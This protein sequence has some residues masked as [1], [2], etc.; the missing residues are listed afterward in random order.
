MI[1]LAI[2]STHEVHIWPI[3]TIVKIHIKCYEDGSWELNT[4]FTNGEREIFCL[5][6]DEIELF[7]KMNEANL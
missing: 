6:K 1:T 5:N 2:E 4:R 3:S 7:Y